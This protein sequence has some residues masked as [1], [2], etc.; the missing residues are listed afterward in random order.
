MPRVN[1]ESPPSPPD[2]LPDSFWERVEDVCRDPEHVDAALRAADPADLVRFH[3]EF[4]D[5]VVE[6]LDDPFTPYLPDSEDGAEDVAHWVVSR[7]R[8]YYRS[9]WADPETFPAWRPG[10]PGVHVGQIASVYHDLTGE[11]LDWDWED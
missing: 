11:T 1:P 10:L 7:G 6:L 3:R 8:A 5:A 2:H 4:L 9:L